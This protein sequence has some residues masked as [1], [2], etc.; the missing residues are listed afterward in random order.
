[1]R[2]HTASSENRNGAHG[3]LFTVRLPAAE[4]SVE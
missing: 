1:M 3:E 4:R 2:A